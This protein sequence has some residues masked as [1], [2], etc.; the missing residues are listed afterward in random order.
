MAVSSVMK[1]LVVVTGFWGSGVIATALSIVLD[2][3]EDPL[4]DTIKN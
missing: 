4:L 2:T 3:E 1:S